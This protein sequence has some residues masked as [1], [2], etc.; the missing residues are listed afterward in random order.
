MGGF[1]A[2]HA[3][4][5]HRVRIDMIGVTR[6]DVLCREDYKM[7][8]ANGIY[9]IRE[10]L[11]WYEIDKGT[12]EYHFGR[13]ETMMRI[14]QEEGMEVIW[15][16]NHFDF[17][18]Y[19]DVFSDQ[20]AL[21]FTQ[22]AVAAARKLRE[23]T[24]GV[25]YINPFNEISFGVWICA[26]LG[27]WAPH[28]HGRAM[29]LKIQVVRGAI[30]AMRAIRAIDNNVQFIQVDPIM[31]RMAEAGAPDHVHHFANGWHNVVCQ[32]WDMIIGRAFPELGGSPD[33]M[34]IVGIN[35][36]VTNQEIIRKHPPHPSVQLP[37]YSRFRIPFVNMIQSVYDRYHKPIII[38]E[39]G[40]YGNLRVPWWRRTLRDVDAALARG[41]PL[42]GV[43]TYPV[44][45]RPDWHRWHLTHS[46]FWDFE[47]GDPTCERIPYQP[48]LNL[49]KRYVKRRTHRMESGTRLSER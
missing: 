36:Y 8:K 30:Q 26:D 2:C 11:G 17:P 40:C 25:L 18:D 34:D 22:Y 42:W 38:S 4:N 31:V 43:C 13:F 29:E 20:Y 15:S 48:V 28:T 19:L 3:L 9:T 39:T 41:I 7:L 5:E 32:A 24:D 10:G 46:G 23:Y 37:M 12:D 49:V 47:E 14:A 45:D 16:L 21:R 27:V 35:Y 1:E 6:H 44:I 33:L